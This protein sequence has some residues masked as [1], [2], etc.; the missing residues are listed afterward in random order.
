M[1]L[2]GNVSGGEM[3]GPKCP[4]PLFSTVDL[5]TPAS[6]KSAVTSQLLTKNGHENENTCCAGLM[7]IYLKLIGENNFFGH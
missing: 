1:V 7:S 6:A 3:S 2:H 5:P 4:I